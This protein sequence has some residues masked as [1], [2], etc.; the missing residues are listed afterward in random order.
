MKKRVWQGFFLAVLIPTQGV[1]AVPKPSTKAPSTCVERFPKGKA[2][3]KW[4]EKFPKKGL[5][6]YAL[7]LKIIIEH[8]K[9]ETVL[10]RHITPES[11]PDALKALS[12]AGFAVPNPEGGAG[13]G[14][15]VS[16]TP[17]GKKS[18]LFHQRCTSA[19]ERWAPSPHPT[20]PSGR[21]SAS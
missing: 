3:P 14:V 16:D 21:H 1:S 5:S 8:G 12:E 9:G 19:Q 6:G 10:P 18:E 17:S 2:K 7:T 20:A 15:K 13:V 11:D 4:S